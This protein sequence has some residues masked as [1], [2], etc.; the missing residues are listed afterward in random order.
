MKTNTKLAA[1]LLNQGMRTTLTQAVCVAFAGMTVSTAAFAQGAATTAVELEEVVITGTSIRG[2]AP[3]GSNLITVG[4]EQ[5]EESGA[6]T[7]QQLL[8]SVPAVTG[9]GNAAQGGFGSADGAGTFAPTIHGLGA[10]ASNGTL[11]LVDGHR[12]PLSGINHTLADPGVIAP[13]AIERVEVLPDGASATYGSDAVAGVLNFITRRN[14]Q[15]FELSGNFGVA[16][17]YDSQDAGF[18]WGDSWDRGSVF[19]TYN[20]THKSALAGADRQDII[21]PDHRD[22]E[23]G[24]FLANTCGVA[25]IAA[26]SNSA[27][28]FPYPYTA[29]VTLPT[30]A[31]NGNCNLSTYSDLLPESLRHNFMVKVSHDVTDTLSVSADVVYSKQNIKAANA[32]GNISAAAFGPGA[33]PPTTAGLP[34]PSNYTA[35]SQVNPFY[36]TGASGIGNTQYVRWQADE[37]LGPGA[38]TK[39]GATSFFVSAGAEQKLGGDWLATLGMT[40]G[41]D[42]SRSQVIGGLCTS[43]ALMALNGT[44]NANGNP[45]TYSVPGTTTAVLQL[46]L[47]TANALDVWNPASSNRTSAAVRATL[48]D[49]TTLQTAHQTLNDITLKFDGSLFNLPGGSV[50]AAVGG[51]YIK[52][53]MAEE[54]QRA[55][56]TGPVSQN[57]TS[58][59]LQL[60]RDVTSGFAE[61]L[62]PIV[63]AGN[64]IP[65]VAGLDLNLAGRYDKYSD[66]GS[67]TNPKY[68]MTWKI[69]D[70]F[71]LRGNYATS[72]TAP[73][74]TSRGNEQG[75]TAES[76]Y[77]AFN[78]TVL[79]PN[80]FPDPNGQLAALR[81]LSLNPSCTPTSNGCLLNSGSLTG[82]QINGGNKDLKP[83]EG[84]T[85]SVGFD[86]NLQAVPGLKVSGTFWSSEYIGAVT[87]PQAVVAANSA[88][89]AYSYTFYPA[90]TGATSAQIDA[91]TA[92]LSPGVRPAATYFFYSF[93]QKNAL[94]LYAN[95]VDAEIGYTF[96]T[97]I[98]TF[99]ADLSWSEKLKMEESLGVGGEK[100]DILNTSGFNTTFPSIGRAAN[101][102]LGWKRNAIS[103]NLQFNYTGPYK[104]WSN[105]AGQGHPSW[106]IVNNS[107]NSP[108]GGGQPIGS[109]VT[110]DLHVA[111]N[112]EDDGMLKDLTISL[113]VQNVTDEKPNF[114]NVAN[115]YDTNAASPLGRL[116]SLGLKKKW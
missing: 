75:I 60:G 57:S 28:L 105:T 106:A 19:V 8:S 22:Q 71:Q 94:N 25:N 113:D 76:S 32:R 54:A 65:F 83:Q 102:D 78:G 69:V 93:Q 42:D 52:Y 86:L 104:N 26:A 111:Y 79:L 58:L 98:G 23:G 44:T 66:F 10:S 77:N 18:L 37:L 30:A 101:L 3:V 72:F 115:G 92:G 85:F 16:D 116:V 112:F 81:A 39:S 38:V 46:P 108:V 35:A 11:V 84:K 70:G 89:L 82:I 62:I 5:I 6:T 1:L 7:I 49:S 53:A 40:L 2:V 68:A 64:A 110:S 99:S 15:G 73:A 21:Y 45:T 59:Y 14:Y 24:N 20:Y 48:I 55:R 56:N 80:S 34:L 4:R 51:E 31:N 27:T 91:M 74:L 103:A 29:G 50:R 100:F 43:C 63:G 67:T 109:A 33:T 88:G 9:F 61:V 95:G 13:L 107:V 114:F 87:A 47:T 41:Q 17:G 97:G 36:T 90:P 96:D 12:L